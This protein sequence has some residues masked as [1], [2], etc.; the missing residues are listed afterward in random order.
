MDK[1]KT[2]RVRNNNNVLIQI[3]KV[4]IEKWGLQNGDSVEMLL[5]PEG[6]SITLKPR[7]GFYDIKPV[8]KD[9]QD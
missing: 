7:R 4:V 9:V 3:P 2:I 6:D 8:F 5:S 1:L